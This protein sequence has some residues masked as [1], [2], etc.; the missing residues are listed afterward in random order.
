M[1]ATEVVRADD[2]KSIRVD[3]FPWANAGIPPA[4]PAIVLAVEAGS[5]MVPG[6]S[7]ADE[8]CIAVVC[9]QGPVTLVDQ[10]IAGQPITAVQLELF[11]NLERLRCHDA[12]GIRGFVRGK[13]QLRR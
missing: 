12:D 9:V 11:G 3:G 2:K 1:T 7:M 6:E 8:H 13:C 5:V 4:G 10:L